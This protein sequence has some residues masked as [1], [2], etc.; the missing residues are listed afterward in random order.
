M[1]WAIADGVV[2]HSATPGFWWAWQTKAWS[3]G[4]REPAAVLFQ[5]EV[6]TMWTT[7]S[8]TISDSGISPADLT[9]TR[10]Y[11]PVGT[12]DGLPT[13]MVM[14]GAAARSSHVSIDRISS[15]PIA[16]HPHVGLPLVT[17]RKIPDTFPGMRCGLTA[18]LTA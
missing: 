15:S 4:V 7:Y 14:R 2:G 8:R 10:G 1:G 6:V 11:D 17:C 9:R 3:D 5:R 13:P 12:N 18:M 16:T